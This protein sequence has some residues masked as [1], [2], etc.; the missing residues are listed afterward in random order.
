MA[1]RGGGTDVRTDKRKNLPILQDFVSY[2]GRCSKRERH[3][4]KDKSC[5][6]SNGKSFLEKKMNIN[7]ELQLQQRKNKFDPNK[8]ASNIC[9]NERIFLNLLEFT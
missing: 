9:E 4:N 3:L 5:L 8:D 1:Q 7:Y 2:R 6:I